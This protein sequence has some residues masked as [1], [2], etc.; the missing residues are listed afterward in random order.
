[1]IEGY[2]WIP[3]NTDRRI[4]MEPE[5]YGGYPGII[6]EGYQE[7][8]TSEGKCRGIPKTPRIHQG[9]FARDAQDPGP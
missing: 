3:R 6:I 8:P 7:I 4:A 1:M 9:G 5:G 2:G